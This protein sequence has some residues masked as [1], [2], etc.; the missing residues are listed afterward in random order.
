MATFHTLTS[1][2]VEPM[3]EAIGFPPKVLKWRAPVKDCA[4]SVAIKREREQKREREKG[5]GRG[6]EREKKR[7]RE[8]LKN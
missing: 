1:S 3:A 5:R 8:G 6:S 7:E 2:T 4:I